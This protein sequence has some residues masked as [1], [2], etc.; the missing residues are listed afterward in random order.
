MLQVRL[1]RLQDRIGLHEAVLGAENQ[2]WQ[3]LPTSCGDAETKQRTGIVQVDG[4]GRRGVLPLCAGDDGYARERWLSS[5][6]FHNV[7]CRINAAHQS[8]AESTASRRAA[9]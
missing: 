6:G 1:V 7:F 5:S 3:V 2:N 4:P 8:R 9:T